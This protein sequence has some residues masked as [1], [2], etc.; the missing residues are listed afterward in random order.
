MEDKSIPI[1]NI[2]QLILEMLVIFRTNNVIL[3]ANPGTFNTHPVKFR[4]NPVLFRINSV[5]ISEN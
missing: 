4:T 2:S 5:T 1:E 3:K